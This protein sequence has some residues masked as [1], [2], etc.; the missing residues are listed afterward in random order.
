M[1]SY[2]WLQR[3]GLPTDGSAEAADLDRDGHTTWQEWRCGTSP[4]NAASV[5]KLQTPSLVRPGLFLSWSGDSNQVYCVERATSLQPPLA[6]SLLQTNISGR[7]PTTD[8]TDTGA[9]P[10]TKR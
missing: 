10:S 1:I 4:V 6:F 9:S 5:L 7:S 2:A 3:Y 8:F